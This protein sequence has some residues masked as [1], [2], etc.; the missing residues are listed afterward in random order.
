MFKWHKKYRWKALDEGYNFSWDFISIGGL[1]TKL[2]AS[3]VAGVP[4]VRQ[5]DI[6]MLVP[7]PC[8]KYTIRGKVEASFKSGSW[9]VLWVRVCPWLVHAPKCS[10]YTLNNLLF[11][12]CKYLWII[13]FLVNLPSPHLKAPARPFTSPKYSKPRSAPQF[14]LFLMSSPF[15]S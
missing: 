4:T 15:D 7:W 2:W 9:W 6:W 10:N 11:G 13:H 3:K 14:L 5:N 8:T 12:L 1:H